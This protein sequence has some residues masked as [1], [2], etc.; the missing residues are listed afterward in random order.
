M[1]LISVPAC[2]RLQNSGRTGWSPLLIGSLP[3]QTTRG[4]LHKV[5]PWWQHSIHHLPIRVTVAEVERILIPGGYFAI[6]IRV[7]DQ[8]SEH[9]WGRW[10]PG[11][12]DHSRVPTREF[13]TN[14]HCHNKAFQLLQVQISLSS[15]KQRLHGSVS[16]QRTSITRHSTGIPIKNFIV[17]T[18]SSRI[19][20]EQ[21]TQT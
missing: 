5:Y 19:I 6:Y 15:E 11:Y 1:E 20:S 21:I 18:L 17:R 7:L 4:Y 3:Q 13:M 14:L 9:I 16:K 8:E 10:F 2:W 12:L